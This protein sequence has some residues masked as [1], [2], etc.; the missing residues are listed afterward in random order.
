M[1]NIRY[2]NYLK[3]YCKRNKIDD[4]LISLDAKKAF[5]SVSHEYIDEVLDR[6]GFGETFRN[7][8]KIL[9]KDITAKILINGYFSEKIDIERGV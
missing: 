5:D 6:Y 4:T 7:Y 2:N 3:E 9:Y 1:D 8:F